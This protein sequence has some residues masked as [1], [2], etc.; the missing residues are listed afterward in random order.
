MMHNHARGDVVQTAHAI[1]AVMSVSQC[2][3]TTICSVSVPN[4]PPGWYSDPW[5]PGA[6][7]WWDG[8]SWSAFAQSTPAWRTPARRALPWQS[9]PW[10]VWAWWLV[11]V[12]I[13]ISVGVG[14]AESTAVSDPA[15]WF[16]V[17]GIG[18]GVLTLLGA[19]TTLPGRRSVA[20]FV[21]AALIAA[22]VTIVVF[23][24]S[25]P[26]SSRS[27]RADRSASSTDCD[28][29]FGLGVPLVTAL[30][31]VPAVTLAA[32]GRAGG[33]IARKRRRDK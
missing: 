31:F 17:G 28:T 7:R 23:S 22:T 2:A 14:M 32:A 19:A 8:A 25:A 33:A 3:S 12:T 29:S 20:V 11:A 5:Y 1:A 9:L 4:P 21:Y 30:L 15:V 18:A 13:V 27:C 24:V 26:A 6:V 16:L 10:Q